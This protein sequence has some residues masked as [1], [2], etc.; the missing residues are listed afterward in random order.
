MLLCSNCRRTV[1][2]STLPRRIALTFGFALVR[3]P[4]RWFLLFLF[5]FVVLSQVQRKSTTGIRPHILANAYQRLTAFVKHIFQTYYNA[6]KVHLA[7]LLD[8]VAN[9]SQI[10]CRKMKIYV[11]RTSAVR[12]NDYI[13]NFC[14]QCRN[15]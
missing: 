6:L 12:S 3:I 15:R 9:F 4:F 11:S 7:A 1:L 10:Y 2:A 5:A 13:T 14:R 8:I